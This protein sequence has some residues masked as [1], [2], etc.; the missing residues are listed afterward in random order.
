MRSYTKTVYEGE[1]L[2]PVDWT[3]N[4]RQHF[5]NMGCSEAVK[6]EYCRRAVALLRELSM[7]HKSYQVVLSHGCVERNVYAVGMYDG[8]PY[9]KA[10]PALLT[11]GT[12]GPEWHFFYDLQRIEK[13]PLARTEPGEGTA[14]E[15][16]KGCETTERKEGSNAKAV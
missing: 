7:D 16:G 5:D 13:K 6:D 14:E 3:Y 10:T 1:L 12:L 11:S 9:W 2:G 4:F 8:W 15:S